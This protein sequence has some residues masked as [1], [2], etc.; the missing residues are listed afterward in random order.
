MKLKDIKNYS[1]SKEL[2]TR[3]IDDSTVMIY[4]PDNG[5]MY[6]MNSVSL[7]IIKMLQNNISGEQILNT[8]ANDYNADV[9]LIAED[10][11]PF[12]DRLLEMK[13]LQVEN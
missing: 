11:Q 1:F 4:N 13:L 5:D 3:V 8:L 12:I 6:E 10:V 7:E 9:N 2:I